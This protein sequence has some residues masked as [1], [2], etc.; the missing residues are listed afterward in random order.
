M[1]RIR[2]GGW[3]AVTVAL[4]AVAL[5]CLRPR[6]TDLA[7]NLAAPHIWVARVGA[8]RAAVTVG[9]AALWCVAL[10]LALGLTAALVAAVPG[11]LGRWASHAARQLLPDA[12]LRAVAG[13][14]GLSILIAPI[15]ADAKGIGGHGALGATSRAGLG[16]SGP[17]PSWPTDA[18]PRTGVRIGWPTDTAGRSMPV[19]ALPTSSAPA[20]PA[21]AVPAPAVPAH[22]GPHA[23][24]HRPAPGVAPLA[25]DGEVHVKPGDSLW[26]IAAQRLGS[27]A[28]PRVIAATWPHWYAANRQVIGADPSMLQPGEVLHAP[29]DRAYQG[30]TP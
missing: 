13:A 15:A 2:L 11:R 6:W 8:D 26:L 17:S 24:P 14:A 19:P 23:H 27:D 10:W 16:T 7:R 29:S 22:S 28:S 9:C 25:G 18:P 3:L 21:P 4:D 1:K 12:M 30:E 5:E 20:A